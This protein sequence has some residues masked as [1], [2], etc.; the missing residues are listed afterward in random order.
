L[1]IDIVHIGEQSMSRF[2]QAQIVSIAMSLALVV[3]TW[4][5]TLTPLA[6]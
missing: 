4:M 5:T 6:A 3:L 1:I 2:D